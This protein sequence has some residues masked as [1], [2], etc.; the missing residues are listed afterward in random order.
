MDKGHDR[1]AGNAQ[2]VSR[3][4]LV[5][6]CGCTLLAGCTSFMGQQDKRAAAQLLP[7]V[8]SQARGTVSFVEHSDGVQVSYN[9]AGLQPDSDH[10]LQV[11][12]RGDCNATDASSAGAV[13][14]P[15]AERLKAGAR[16]E[17]DLGNI[18]ADSNGVA[19]GFIVAPDVSLD[20][21]RSVLQRAVI[22]HRDAIDPYAYPQRGTGPA[23]ACGVIRAQ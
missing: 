13:F 21:V 12:E 20:G 6:L 5:V 2:V 23:L 8:G 18:H 10:A 17:G 14:A 4:A 15:A 9:L 19:S 22:V 3:I 7:T 16:V 1:Q 11:H